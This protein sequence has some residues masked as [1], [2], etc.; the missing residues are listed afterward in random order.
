MKKIITFITIT[1]L[2]LAM[3][4]TINVSALSHKPNDYEIIYEN[5][6]KY[7]VDYDENGEIDTVTELP[8]YKNKDQE[9]KDMLDN[10]V[11]LKDMLKLNVSLKTILD[12]GGF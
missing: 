4:G 2:T 6:H 10:N 3:A 9:L 11:P 5:N 8:M 7:R 12:E 1:L